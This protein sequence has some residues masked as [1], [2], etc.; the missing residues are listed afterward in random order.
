M[1]HKNLAKSLK[2]VDTKS[3]VVTFYA[4]SFN[5]EDDS[6]EAVLPGG[7]TKTL[8]EQGPASKQPRIKHLYQH[9]TTALLSMP[10]LLKEDPFGLYVESKIVPTTLGRDVLLLYEAGVITEHS[11]GYEVIQAEWDRQRSVR[12][13]KELRLYEVSSVTWGANSDT[14]TVS[15]KSLTDGSQ[16]AT[17]ATKAASID[18]LLHSGNLQSDTIC[19]LLE[20]DL[21]ALHAA[22][23]PADDT[24]AY[25]IQG[26]TQAMGDL[27][28]RLAIKAATD[29]DKKAQAARSKRYHIGVKDGGAVTKPSKWSSVP[30][31]QWGDPVNYRYPMA[32]KSHADDAA[33]RFTA[34]TAREQY[35]AAEQGIIA[36]RIMAR[37][38]AFDETPDWWPIKEESGKAQAMARQIKGTG[39][40]ITVSDSGTH[41]AYTG[42]HSHTHK[43]MGAQGDDA[44]HD[45]EHTHD[46]DAKHGHSHKA[47]AH[48]PARKARDFDTLF[49]SLSA[50]DQLQDDWGDTFIAFTKAMVELMWQAN[51]VRNGWLKVDEDDPFDLMAAAKANIDAFSSKLLDLVQQSD[52]ADFCPCL[53]GD[54]DQILDPDGINAHDDDDDD[55]KSRAPLTMP[56]A[57]ALLAKA[58]RAI[59]SANRKIITDALD[60]MSL[61][62][63]AMQG[64]HGT[65]SD[66]M[67]KTDP[68]AVRQDEDDTQGDDDEENGGHNTN[69]SQQA[70]GRQKQA[71]TTQNT[72]KITAFDADLDALAIRLKAR[73][74]Q[75]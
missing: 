72:P 9:D 52:D 47:G 24:R 35:T 63:K 2:D 4:S 22:L 7:F 49:A 44:M 67:T 28:D 37:Q 14:P 27:A 1:L 75:A 43:A 34:E 18:R 60:G 54:G 71:G 17:L 74:V 41:A 42:T 6:R 45:H 25:T 38:R 62:M 15:V 39:G 57:P 16:L 55:W 61:A 5:K 13:L 65:I 46:G 3:G 51:S 59:G 66:L 30:D 11:I 53:D 23:A 33:A 64:H 73:K 29:D 12:L 48:A 20:R 36:K 31:S 56:E 40:A 26:V 70:P 68:D 19:E 50:S 21:K 32:D 69:K 58:G 8:A 10:Q